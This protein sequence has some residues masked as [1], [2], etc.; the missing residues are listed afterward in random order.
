MP[1]H[2]LAKLGL[3]LPTGGV[4]VSDDDVPALVADAVMGDLAKV[5]A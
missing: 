3:S 4:R 1:A 5:V 2:Q